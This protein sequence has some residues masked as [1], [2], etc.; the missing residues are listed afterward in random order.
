MRQTG[1]RVGVFFKWETQLWTITQTPGNSN[2][3]PLHKTLLQSSACHDEVCESSPSLFDEWKT[4]QVA[5]DLRQS[6]QTW[7]ESVCSL[8]LAALN[9]TIAL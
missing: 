4:V 6:Q 5:A 9:I 8:L 1:P 7:P 3:T 2:N